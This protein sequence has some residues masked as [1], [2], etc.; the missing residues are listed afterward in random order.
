[1]VGEQD[2]QVNDAREA[3]TRG[4]GALA[5]ERVACA[6]TAALLLEAHEAHAR[7]YGERDARASEREEGDWRKARKGAQDSQCQHE[8]EGGDDQEG[9]RCWGRRTDA[10]IHLLTYLGQS[11]CDWLLGEKYWN[12]SSRPK[13]DLVSKLTS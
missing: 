12:T 9:R 5:E 11:Y 1:M 6:A 7:R 13:K 8:A 10:Q 2:G 3:I 4:E